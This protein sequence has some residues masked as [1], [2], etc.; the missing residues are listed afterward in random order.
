MTAKIEGA[1]SMPAR[2]LEE[3][4]VSPVF[5]R[6][7][8]V[9]LL[10]FVAL[11]IVANLLLIVAFPNIL[12][13]AVKDLI[14]V[15][16]EGNG[17]TWVNSTLFMTVALSIWLVAALAYVKKQAMATSRRTLL[18]WLVISAV[19]V[20]LSI[21][22]A[23]QL[24]EAVARNTG[25][26]LAFLHVTDSTILSVS[27]FL[28]IP[29]LGIPG[30]VIMLWMLRFFYTHIW[31]VRA[32]R[33]MLVIGALLLLSNPLTELPESQI[34]AANG[35]QPLPVLQQ[36]NHDAWVQLKLLTI[37]Q[38]ATE[39]AAPVFFIAGFLLVGQSIL[40]RDQESRQQSV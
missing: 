24:H 35:L 4:L 6:R 18:G 15:D 3:A 7:L 17:A 19:F 31:N 27:P 21:D 16:T 37:T 40:K 29:L 33:N 10:V 38:E 1:S 14:D 36:T 5:I 11:L 23:A 32:A 25:K 22:D 9:G 13:G 34:N 8:T 39:F 30:V 26:M 28:W 12:P 2:T 20:Y